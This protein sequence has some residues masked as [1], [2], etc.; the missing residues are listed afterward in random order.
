MRAMKAAFTNPILID[1]N[2]TILAGHGRLEPALVTCSRTAAPAS[3][4]GWGQQQVLHLL[5]P[6]LKL[7]GDA[8]RWEHLAEAEIASHFK[9]CN[10]TN[11]SDAVKSRGSSDAND[12]RWK[13]VAAA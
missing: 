3:P 12:T 4:P 6:E 2:D 8:E 7:L 5:L 10:T 11:S 9:E 1:E 13:T